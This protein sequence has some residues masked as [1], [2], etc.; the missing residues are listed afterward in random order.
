MW[1]GWS[2]N[3]IIHWLNF[4]RRWN[5]TKYNLLRHLKCDLRSK[6]TLASHLWGRVGEPCARNTF[7]EEP[8]EG[9]MAFKL[10]PA[11]QPTRKLSSTLVYRPQDEWVGLKH[12]KWAPIWAGAGLGPTQCR[13][14]LAYQIVVFLIFGRKICTYLE[15]TAKFWP[16]C[17]QA[18]CC[19]HITLVWTLMKLRRCS[20]LGTLG[21][22]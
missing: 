20:S 21:V 14:A 19:P 4:L 16:F 6:S 12:V 9:G 10:A 17:R 7:R 22:S 11:T 8:G 2:E 15:Q 5:S 18:A 13:L 3:K 1:F